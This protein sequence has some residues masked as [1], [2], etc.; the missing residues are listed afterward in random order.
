MSVH[1]LSASEL[2]FPVP[3]VRK[4]IRFDSHML[5][6]LMTKVRNTVFVRKAIQGR[7]ALTKIGSSFDRKYRP[8]WRPCVN[9]RATVG[10]KLTMIFYHPIMVIRLG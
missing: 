4:A 9:L 6:L 1:W 3:S 8:G 7:Y 2:E 5:G 10:T